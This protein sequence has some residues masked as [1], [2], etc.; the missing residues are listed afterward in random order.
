V[1]SVVFF[2]SQIL[3]VQK[4]ALLLSGHDLCED[5]SGKIRSECPMCRQKFSSSPRKPF[6]NYLRVTPVSVEEAAEKEATKQEV[7]NMNL[8]AEKAIAICDKL[9]VSGNDCQ[10]AML[11]NLETTAG[12][13]RGASSRL[14]SRDRHGSKVGTP[15]SI[16][17]H[18]KFTSPKTKTSVIVKLVSIITTLYQ[19]LEM[20]VKSVHRQLHAA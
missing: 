7:I 20:K 9:N 6:V 1:A 10:M 8:L 2:L 16:L 19:S 13:L 12:L 5:C 15:L 17:S 18:L 4:S 11:Q 3:T 14:L